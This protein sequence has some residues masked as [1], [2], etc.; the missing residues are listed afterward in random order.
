MTGTPWH[1]R[2]FSI[3]RFRMTATVLRQPYTCWMNYLEIW[4]LMTLVD[5]EALVQLRT[6]CRQG[7]HRWV[8]IDPTLVRMWLR[9]CLKTFVHTTGNRRWV[10]RMERDDSWLVLQDDL[11]P[12]ARELGIAYTQYRIPGCRRTYFHRNEHFSLNRATHQMPW[13]EGTRGRR[14]RLPSREREPSTDSASLEHMKHE[15]GCREKGTGSTLGETGRSNWS[16][17]VTATKSQHFDDK[18]WTRRERGGR[19]WQQ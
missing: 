4:L 12:E 19:Q 6:C 5:L 1:R 7:Y 13:S 18:R 9:Q 2:P 16:K 11:E 17:T 3:A 14:V 15:P 8:T 10:K